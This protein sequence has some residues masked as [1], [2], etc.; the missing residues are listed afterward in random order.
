MPSISMLHYC[1]ILQQSLSRLL[2]LYCL[3]RGH[4]IIYVQDLKSTLWIGWSEVFTAKMECLNTSLLCYIFAPRHMLKF[5]TPVLCFVNSRQNGLVFPLSSSHVHKW[6]SKLGGSC[7]LG[8]VGQHILM[9]NDGSTVLLPLSFSTKVGRQY[10]CY[11][12]SR[13][14][15]TRDAATLH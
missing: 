5:A 2:W 1:R 3:R 6:T 7:M 14:W 4:I 11:M 13:F 8:S 15:F 9:T 12:N 10:C